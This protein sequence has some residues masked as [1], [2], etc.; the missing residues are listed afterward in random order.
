MAGPLAG[1]AEP[2]AASGR[3][4]LAPLLARGPQA[5]TSSDSEALA[6]LARLGPS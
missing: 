3:L 2:G 1:P 5:A 4:R 6:R